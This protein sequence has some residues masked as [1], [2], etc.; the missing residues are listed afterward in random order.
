MRPETGLPVIPDASFPMHD[1]NHSVCLCVGRGAELGAGPEDDA[2]MHP[3]RK[4]MLY[5]QFGKDL[6]PSKRLDVACGEQVGGTLIFNWA[7][8]ML[9]QMDRK[10]K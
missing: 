4:R 2:N 9:H 1:S 6:W 3:G 10:M 8:H 5:K 7:I